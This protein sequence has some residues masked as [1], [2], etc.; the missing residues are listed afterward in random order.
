M[1]QERI[2]FQ[3][4]E[5][6]SGHKYGN[7]TEYI[8]KI[9]GR[10]LDNQTISIDVIGFM[11]YFF[12]EVPDEW[13]NE[14]AELF[15]NEIREKADERTR[16]KYVCI[17]LLRRYKFWGFSNKK[18]FK[19]VLFKFR[20]YYTFS[21]YRKI[22]ET[23]M[24]NFRLYESNLNP[25]LRC[26]HR[27][28][29]NSC[30]W[31]YVT[32]YNVTEG[33]TCQLN[34]E[35]S[36]TSIHPK[37]G[38]DSDMSDFTV[39]AVDIECVS[40]DGNFPQPS[41]EGDKIIMIATTFSHHYT[42]E[43][44]HK[45]VIVLGDCN[46]IEGVEVVQ[47]K[48]EAQV[49]KK[50]MQLIAR[51]NPDMIT[52]W[53]IF[54]FDEN[55]INKRCELLG[56]GD[57]SGLSRIIGEN[58]KFVVKE[59]A[60][61]ALGEN[62]LK[63]FDTTGRIHFDLMKVVQKDIKLDSYKLDYVSSKFFREK[64]IR[65]EIDGETTVIH[66]KDTHGMKVGQYT[67]IVYN[68]G[69]IDYEHM[70]KK[71]FRIIL[72]S[73]NKITIAGIIEIETLEEY[74][75]NPKYAVYW[76]QVKDDVKPNEIFAKF[77]G[78]IDDRT[79]LAMYNIQD[80]ELC[81]K[82]VAKLQIVIDNVCMANVCNVPLSYL[83]MRGQG[84]KIFSLVSKKCREKRYVIPVIKC[85]KNADDANFEGAKVFEPKPGLYLSPIFVLDYASLY[86]NSMRFR[87]LSHE[88][89]VLD[90][91]YMNCSDYEYTKINYNK[92]GE[93]TECVFAK[94]I[95]NEPG[96]LPEILT[97]LITARSNTRKLIESETNAFKKKVLDRMQLAYK[98][99]ANSLYG[100]TGAPTSP[101]YMEEIAACTT[102]T[103]RYMLDYSKNFIENIYCK[104]INNA[105]TMQL[106]E[107][108]AFAKSVFEYIDEF[109]YHPND[110]KFS[111][112]LDKCTCNEK[113]TTH[114][115]RLLCRSLVKSQKNDIKGEFYEALY[116]TIRETLKSEKIRPTVIYGDTDSVFVNPQIFSNTTGK[117]LT[118]KNALTI[119]IKLGIL[120][121]MIICI[122]LP[123]PMKQEY[124]KTLWP[125]MQISKKRYV[126][127]LY[128]TNPN[129]YT[130]K[131]MGI[132][133]KRRDN[134]QIVK[135]VCGGIIDQ[136]LNHRSPRGAIDYARETLHKI[137]T[138]YYGMDKFIITKSL[139]IGYKRRESIAHAILAD[140]IGM[141]DPGNCPLPN[142]RIQYVFVVT[143]KEVK[144][145]GERIETPEY[146]NENNLEIDYLYYLTNQI[147]K[148]AIQF[149][150]L[151]AKNPEDL[152]NHV[153][154]IE[155]N[156][157]IGKMPFTEFI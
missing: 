137:M 134:A 71:K 1:E 47:C 91:K 74:L 31:A 26:I 32:D 122:F 139:K 53:N 123:F 133:L 85:D 18:K 24:P 111:S 48:N 17:S 6:S 2:I 11:P 60:S 83:F 39:A 153:I 146:V 155:K 73:A 126:G 144:M 87:N 154:M 143:E 112:S 97:E 120:A 59:L 19:F 78:T 13:T 36:Y 22:L 138:N 54:G 96:I 130:Q 140:R 98:T 50:W 43:C 113:S 141:R 136:L 107:Y 52:G 86:P 101:L 28:G 41:R 64:I 62:V 81:N 16:R 121:S 88:C 90:T 55:Y 110:S 70:N 117:L 46:P 68:D 14:H 118:D 56:V 72:L 9:F 82:L 25:L 94:S 12:V 58:S 66:T 95:N 10:T 35:A 128:E 37:A 93:V 80:C 27:I 145:Q 105:I 106:G 44:Y 156:R 76:C 15:H 57:T 103:G 8:I 84:V 100:Q 99:T 142:D 104:I 148:P 33:T 102:A 89:I 67:T 40:I 108:T 116:H 150:Q 34:I 129:S 92:G 114:N 157:R 4:L 149:L 7:E 151:V 75:A 77:G 49:L 65:F 79:E 21:N 132:V 135:I 29:V 127:N 147:M 23:Q 124:E 51:M 69:I 42:D 131:S 20:D 125:F 109:K 63:Y 119:S 3:I 38:M 152:F 115:V 30:G 45:N 5:W 61:S